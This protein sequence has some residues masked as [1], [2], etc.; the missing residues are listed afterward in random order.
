MPAATSFD[1]NERFRCDTAHIYIYIY[2]FT[3][4]DENKRALAA[5]RG[6]VFEAV[7]A[8]NKARSGATGL[9]NNCTRAHSLRVSWECAIFYIDGDVATPLPTTSLLGASTNFPTQETYTST[10]TSHAPHATCTRAL[11]MMLGPLA[12]ATGRNPHAAPLPNKGVPGQRRPTHKALLVGI[13][14]R[15]QRSE[16][17]GCI[18]DIRC[19]KHMLIQRFKWPESAI[20]MLSE[21]ERDPS[22]RP[23]KKNM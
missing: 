1:A 13:V 16:L 21:D 3:N 17:K 8:I 22:R 20:V 2:R 5:S 23:T 6:D 4:R 10:N 7:G 15:G 9:S 18:N 12:M 19:V 14:Y 11:Q